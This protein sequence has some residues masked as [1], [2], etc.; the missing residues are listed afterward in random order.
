MARKKIHHPFDFAFGVMYNEF[1]KELHENLNIPGIFRRKSNVKVRLKDGSVLEMDA[2]YVADPD[3]E[4][5]FE[6]AVVNL[7]HMSK[8]V[9]SH[10]IRII[11]NY[12]IQQIADE[13]LPPLNVIA[14]HLSPE[15]SVHEFE[16]TP[17]S[18]TKLMFLDLGAEDNEKRLNKLKNIINYNEDKL[19]IK[20][21]LNLGIVALFAQ[22]EI[23]R[24]V[25]RQVIELYLKIKVMPKKLEYALYS[26]LYAMVDAY[27]EDE[28]EYEE[29]INMINDGAADEI[30]GKFETEIISQNKIIEL[31]KELD[32]A[33]SRADSEALRA[34]N[35]ALRADNAE[36]E[37]NRLKDEINML[38]NQ[39]NSK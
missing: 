16:R 12:N 13:R 8:A 25:T 4:R 18:T 19:T 10:K 21:A 37:I 30:V 24:E 11:G 36:A 7:E 22:R 32:S 39:L 2:S 5:L 33:N 6:P 29:L 20:D 34:N 3:F 27:F 17:T 38:K 31:E 23:A 15:K 26:V 28:N 9:G 14:S 1:P 35:E